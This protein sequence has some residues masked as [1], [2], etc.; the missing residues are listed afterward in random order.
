MN[1]CNVEINLKKG[2]VKFITN[3][4]DVSKYNSFA[5]ILNAKKIGSSSQMHKRNCYNIIEYA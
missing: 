5:I 3:N 4:P 1:K 2:S